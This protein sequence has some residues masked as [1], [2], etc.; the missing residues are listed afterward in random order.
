MRVG[1][2]IYILGCMGAVAGVLQAHDRDCNA[3]PSGWAILDVAVWPV[4]VAAMTF[5]DG[6]IAADCED[7]TMML[8]PAPDLAE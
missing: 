7:G 4:I 2:A 6:A 1:T 3:A 8:A 5:S